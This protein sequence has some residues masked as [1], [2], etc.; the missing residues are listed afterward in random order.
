MKTSPCVHASHVP[1]SVLVW[2]SEEG[3]EQSWTVHN[4]SGEER[5]ASCFWSIDSIRLEAGHTNVTGSCVGPTDTSDTPV[6]FVSI[7]QI[8]LFLLHFFASQVS[9]HSI[10]TF[11]YGPTIGDESNCLCREKQRAYCNFAANNLVVASESLVSWV[12]TQSASRT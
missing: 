10:L 12:R 6:T 5:P 2:R 11:A 9:T 7:N 3:Q 8:R 1:L 4:R